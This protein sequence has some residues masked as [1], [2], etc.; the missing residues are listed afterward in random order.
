MQLASF[1]NSYITWSESFNFRLEEFR[2]THTP[3]FSNSSAE[4]TV[5]AR[6]K[7]LPVFSEGI[8]PGGQDVA[9]LVYVC[10]Q[11][12]L[13][14]LHKSVKVN[15]HNLIQPLRPWSMHFNKN[16]V[17][18]QNKFNILISALLCDFWFL[19]SQLHLRKLLSSLCV[20]FGQFFSIH[21][22]CRLNF[23]QAQTKTPSSLNLWPG[24]SQQQQSLQF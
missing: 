23:Y 12:K 11:I 21:Q 13:P 4:T 1:A 24:C 3:L 6:V 15:K 20:M 18:L 14:S 16:Q 19:S 22:D 9:L 7:F 10:D 8:F 2:D 17:L 5:D